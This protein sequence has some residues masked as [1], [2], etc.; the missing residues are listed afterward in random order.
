MKTKIL[1]QRYKTFYSKFLIEKNKTK[2]LEYYNEYFKYLSSAAYKGYSEAQ[3][4]LGFWY[5]VTDGY[6]YFKRKKISFKKFLYWTGKSAEQNNAYAIAALAEFYEITDSKY[7]DLTKSIFFY[8]KHYEL[9]GDKDSKRN[10]DLI[11]RQVEQGL[12]IKNQ[13]GRM[14]LVK[15]WKVLIKQQTKEI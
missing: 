4:E 3:Y 11:I 8:K 10:Y 12:Y 5:G 13:K 2:K 6:T 14:E 9:V 1:L 7:Q 15:N